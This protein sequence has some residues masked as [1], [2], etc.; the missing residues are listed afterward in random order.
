[1]RLEVDIAGYESAADALNTANQRAAAAYDNLTSSLSGTSGMGGDDKSSEEFV[2]SY[3][4]SARQIVGAIS[5][6]VTALATVTVVTESSGANHRDANN[7][8]VYRGR[9]G[10]MT[11]GK[12][13]SPVEVAPYT[14]PSALGS[15]ASDTPM[16]WDLIVDHLQ[17]WAWPSA[18]T[19]RLR[20][21]SATWRAVATRLEAIPSYTDVA[22]SELGNQRSPETYKA[23]VALTEIGQAADDLATESRALATACEDYAEQVEQTKETVKG[24][25]KDLGIEVGATAFF[26]G[27]GSL[28]TFGGAAAAG[29]L[30]A[31]G[32]AVSYA[33]KVITALTAI[34]AVHAVIV[35]AKTVDKATDVRRILRKYR[36]AKNMRK[37][38]TGKLPDKGKPNSY[39][40]DTHGNRLP[41]ANSRPSYGEDQVDDVWRQAMDENS[42]VWVLNKDGDLVKVDWQPGQPRKNVWDMGHAPGEEYRTLRDQYL[43]GRI[44]KEEFLQRYR[45]PS[46]Y[47]VQHPGRNRSGIDE[48]V[49]RRR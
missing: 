11:T 41:Y 35:L 28:A 43:S 44:S 24:L 36:S 6:L 25:L 4:S 20:Q 29:G 33:K 8:S 30:V 31:A 23:T 1:M 48:A 26:A 39:G 7:A 18:D 45:D 22:I 46:N 49:P 13:R 42:E 40:Y 19:G 17:G 21:A 14:P 15:D 27:L 5:D 10:Q 37:R 32:R 47:E 2:S 3:D 34:K 16:F 12:N 9:H 38:P